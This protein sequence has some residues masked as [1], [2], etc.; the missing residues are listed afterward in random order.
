VTTVAAL[1]AP[2]A[3]A[4]PYDRG[5]GVACAVASVV[6]GLTQSLTV[7]GINNNLPAVQGALGA[8]AVEASWLNTAY[9]ATALSAVVPLTK[10]RLQFGLD[11]F[12]T[13]SIVAFAVVCAA[14][15]LAPSLGT[16]IAARAALGFAA[17]PLNT[18]AVL[19]MIEAMPPA[20]IPVGAVLGFGTVQLGSP[21]AR[22]I[23][24]PLF[25]ATPGVGLALFD[26]ALAFVALATIHV[27]R[28]RPPP[29][30]QIFNAGDMPAFALYAAGLACLCIFVTQG[31]ARWWTDTPWLGWWLCAG[32]ACLGAYVIVDLLRQQPLVDLRW[33]ANPAMRWFIP[34]VVLFR[35]ALSEQ[36]SGALALM[37][38]LGFTNEQMEVLFAWVTFGI[39]TGFVLVVVALMAR[40]LRAALLASLVLIVVASLMDADSSSLTHPHNIVLSQ[41]LIGMATAMFLGSTFV[42]G[43]VPVVLDG[44]RNIVSFL[45]MFVGAQYMGSLLGSALLGTYVYEQQQLHVGRLVQSIS[46]ADPQA[47]LR[48]AQG[49]AAQAGV[50]ADP[51]LRGALGVASLAQ[52]VARE[53]WVLAYGDLFRWIAVAAA[54]ACAVLAAYWATQ[55]WIQRA[56]ATAATP[57]GAL[58]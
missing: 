1:P 50:V 33:L 44:Q 39:A 30:R 55:W 15:L 51:L 20:L 5:H 9:F 53:A 40:S 54:V 11:R 29:L 3:D 24:Q 34:G 6:V 21:L 38:I 26:L 47:V 48:A 16:A 18:L 31:R 2:P 41:T 17:T 43:I 36:P 10:L 22:V 13:W 8:T 14:Y 45:G 25:D 49:A 46:F 32:I 56:N 27:V 7:W 28:L 19:Y 23:G 42:L 35:I 12:A 52:R 58:P 4:P 57:S 37:N